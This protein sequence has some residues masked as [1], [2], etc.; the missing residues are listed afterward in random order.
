MGAQAER[1]ALQEKLKTDLKAKSSHARSV[2]L[3]RA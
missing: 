3:P 2:P 1:P